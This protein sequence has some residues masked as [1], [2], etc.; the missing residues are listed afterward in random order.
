[1]HQLGDVMEMYVGENSDGTTDV[2]GVFC[3][4]CARKRKN[5]SNGERISDNQKSEQASD[6]TGVL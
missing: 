2:F 1:M 4:L 5:L 6:N 3:E